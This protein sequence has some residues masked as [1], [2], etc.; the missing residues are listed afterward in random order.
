MYQQTAK[1]RVSDNG[2][3]LNVFTSPFHVDDTRIHKVAAASFHGS[4]GGDGGVGAT[5]VVAVVTAF[6]IG[7]LF[8]ELH[9]SRSF[10]SAE[11]LLFV[12]VVVLPLSFSAD[13]SITSSCSRTT[14]FV[15]VQ[16]R[17]V[18]SAPLLPSRTS[19]RSLRTRLLLL[20]L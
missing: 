7:A 6:P 2:I 10:V 4:V 3:M 18:Q 8:L 15:P 12:R 19:P 9:Y 11:I 14:L 17:I 5:T 1:M 13:A 16:I 20:W